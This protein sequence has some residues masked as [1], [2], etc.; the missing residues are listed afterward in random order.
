MSIG[1]NVPKGKHEKKN[2]VCYSDK[3]EVLY[4]LLHTFYCTI[5]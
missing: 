5:V 3:Y 4:C 1:E 2:Q